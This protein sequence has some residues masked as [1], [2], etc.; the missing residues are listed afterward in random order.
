VFFVAGR[1]DAE[2]WTFKVIRRETVRT[3]LGQ[4]DAVHLVRLPPPDSKDQ[5]LDIWLSPSHEW[6]PVRVRFTDSDDEFVDQTV[7]KITK[8]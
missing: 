7:E 1:R 3:G 2:Q 8:K 6:Y 5:T 4:V